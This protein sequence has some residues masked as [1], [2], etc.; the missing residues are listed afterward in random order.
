M[1]PELRAGERWQLTVRL[2]RP[3]GTLNSYGFDYEAWLLERDIRATGY[4]RV[5]SGN[6]RI[7]V[8]VPRPQYW[9]ERVREA[10][11]AR[12]Q[13]ALADS[14]YAGVLTAL[15]VGDQP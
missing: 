7:A 1:L 3:H 12:I 10:V 14:P 4:V 8:L 6:R 9:I 2:R 15:A 11:R 5:D 13:T